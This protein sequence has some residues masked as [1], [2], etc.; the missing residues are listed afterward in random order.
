MP[1][2]PLTDAIVALTTYANTV[3]GESDT[4]L[5]AAVETLIDGY[6]G[7]GSSYV[8]SVGETTSDTSTWETLPL[9]NNLLTGGVFEAEIYCPTPNTDYDN[10]IGIGTNKTALSQWNTVDAINI[11]LKTD[12]LE[13][14]QTSQLYSTETLDMTV[15]HTIKIDKDYVYIDSV[16][17]VATHANIKNASTLVIGECQGSK[18]YTG[19]FNYIHFG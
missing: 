4:T 14:R 5:S 9:P 13:V 16:P 1:S 2:T 19:K 8:F 17:M 11:F 10:V 6:G 3:T 12:I 15:P 7:G 18:R